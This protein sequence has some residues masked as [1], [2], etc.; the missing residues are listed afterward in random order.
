MHEESD[1]GRER[2]RLLGRQAASSGDSAAWFEPLYR[3]ANGDDV[4]VPWADNRPNPLLVEWLDGASPR[5]GRGLVV[6]CGLGD[7]AEAVAAA[8]YEVTAFDLSPTAVHWCRRRW[9]ESRVDYQVADAAAPPA[10]WLGRFDLIVES[11]TLQAVRDPI[12]SQIV[13]L[14]P[15]WLRVEGRLIVICRL[16]EPDEPEDGPPWPL[17]REDLLPLHDALSAEQFDVMQDPEQPIVRRCRATYR[18]RPHA[19][20]D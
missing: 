14:L 5:G 3:A 15:T 16:R 1:V 11:Y 6:G 10:T 4:Q 2:A 19:Q 17:T 12:R 18:K 8:G 13:H 7:D 9:P 20:G